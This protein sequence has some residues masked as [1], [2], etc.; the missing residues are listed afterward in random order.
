MGTVFFES[1]V[2]FRFFSSS[3]QYVGVYPFRRNIQCNYRVFGS[4]DYE[5]VVLLLLLPIEHNCRLAADGWKIGSCGVVVVVVLTHRAQPSAAEHGW[6]G[7][8]CAGGPCGR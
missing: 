7:T 6:M 1:I 5:V 2:Y 4:L 3:I 8:T